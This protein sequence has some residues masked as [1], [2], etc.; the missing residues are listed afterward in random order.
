M[1]LDPRPVPVVTEEIVEGL[2]EL[3]FGLVGRIR[4]ED[5]CVRLHHLT[6]RPER[7]SVSIRERAASAPD[8]LRVRV[9]GFGELVDEAALADPG[10]THN[11]YELRFA[12]LSR[13]R[14]RVDQNVELAPSP[15]ERRELAANRARPRGGSER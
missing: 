13:A 2:T 1:T 9:D 10:Y 15:D 7:D 3:R 11:R 8:E 14:E 12:F 5:P 4:L 6:E